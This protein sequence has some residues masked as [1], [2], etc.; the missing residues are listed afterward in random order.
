MHAQ[1]VTGN[2][3][4]TVVDASGA[5]IAGAKVVVTNTATG[6]STTLTSNDQG[7]YN[8]PDLVVGP[9]QV[10]A[11]KE[12]FQTV[13]QKNV[14]LTVGSQLVVNLTL[15][16]G[17]TQQTVTVET[18]VAQVETQSTAISSLVSPK[19]MV[20]LPLNGRNY[21]QLLNLAPGVTPIPAGAGALYGN[22]ASFSIAGARSEGEEFLLDDTNMQDFWNHQA[23]SAALG[24]TLG[25][26]AIQEFTLLTNT[27]SAQFGGNGAVMNAVSKSG[28]NEFH[29]SAYE[30]LR[31]SALDSRSYFDLTPTLQPYKPAFRQNQFGG[32]LGGPIK[33]NKLFFFGNYE[34]LRRALGQTVSGVTLPEPYVANGWVPSS[35]IFGPLPPSCTGGTPSTPAPTSGGPY[36]YIPF[37]CA[38]NQAAAAGAIQG[39]L[40]VYNKITPPANAKDLG[41]YYGT[42][43]SAAQ[44]S[45]ENYVLGRVDYTLSATDNI[46][47]RYVSDRAY[48]LSPIAAFGSDL[49]YWP[50]VD[51]TKNQYFT[52]EERHIFSANVVNSARFIFVR[53]NESS[54]SNSTLPA[55]TD[56]LA[57]IPSRHEDGY[58]SPCILCAG[59][60]GVGSDQFVSDTIAQNTFGFG[61]DVA[62]NHGAHTITFGADINRVQSN[63]Y[64]PFMYGN[65]YL[66]L[67]LPNFLEGSSLFAYGVQQSPYTDIP[68]RYFR[69]IDINPYIN[70]SWKVSSRL[71]LNIGVR[72]DYGTNPSGWPFYT[73]LNPP[74]GNGGFSP[75]S[76]AFQT[77]PN[78]KNIDPRI[79]L[80]W[81]PFGDQKTSIRAGFGIFHDPVAP[82]TYA[83]AYYFSPPFNY[84]QLIGPGFPDPFFGA[85]PALPPQE[86]PT[87]CA[88]D[89]IAFNNT[90]C[91]N[92]GDGVPYTTNVAPYQEQWNLNVQRE[93]GNGT[94]LTVGYVGSRG[95]HLFSQRNLNPS[96]P[97]TAVSVVGG[98]PTGTGSTC[99]PTRAN[100]SSCYFG[101]FTSAG[102]GTVEPLLP[103]LN[104]NYSS[105][106]ENVT[107]GNS[108]YNSLQVSLVRQAARGVTMQVSYTYSHCLDDGSGSY[109][110]EL[111]ALG[112]L[113]P[114]DPR[115]DYGDCSFDLRHNLVANVIYQLPFHGNR[116]VEGWQL[117][118][119]F[120]GQSGLPFSISGGFDQAGLFNNAQSTRPDAIPGCNPYVK[121]TRAP[122]P[123]TGVLSP[124]WINS[125]CF[126]L[127]PAGTLGNAGR[128]T[129]VGPRNIN[130]DFALLKNTRIT[131]RLSA[132]FR[133]EFFNIA[134][135]TD[136]LA[137]NASLYTGVCTAGS[138]FCVAAPSGGD[139]GTNLPTNTYGFISGTRLNSQREIQFAVKLI[140]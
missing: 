71:T 13:L 134:N 106:N 63:V 75:V 105:L 115:Y 101:A 33:K 124:V 21:E 72:Y 43:V 114:Y 70:D 130:L 25:V 7:R 128:N 52:I 120:T 98:I 118:G 82:R 84:H 129:L 136:F 110:L 80:A 135:R 58:V 119:I 36:T 19:Q 92:L 65:F 116:L 10:Q 99:V 126:A 11:T 59:M 50:E 37:G 121:N 64:A 112:Q 96:I 15:Q 31:N 47:G 127:Q 102:G 73:I 89:N 3:S 45:S 46:F 55:A 97:N 90:S 88:L 1:A 66:F 24:T 78:R 18:D 87:N 103:R 62:W 39:I 35:S 8:A 123:T 53:T 60:S 108:N 79:G 12:G 76:H 61:D 91:V 56:P 132:Q 9:Y 23:G 16:V 49:P 107:G 29:G 138:P 68:N 86:Q 125:S 38:S 17:Q 48:N 100:L 54:Y 81:A 95:V 67:T 51:H 26:E 40:G 77:S 2:I 133:A 117:S 140:F 94:V 28:T 27:Y 111:G 34:G 69:E 113:N 57:F 139:G 137:P 85:P 30:F 83:S 32:S 44:N 14:N 41:G 5:V 131:E 6:V 109:G 42:T 104:N 122:S 22:G 93:I 20:D 4:G 74:Y